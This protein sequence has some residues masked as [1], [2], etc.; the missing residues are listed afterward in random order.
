[1]NESVLWAIPMLHPLP[2]EE[3]DVVLPLHDHNWEISLSSRNEADQW[4][5]VSVPSMQTAEGGI[6]TYRRKLAIPSTWEGRRFFLR[7]DG[8]NCLTRVY[9]DGHYIMDHYGGF[10]SWDCPLESILPGSSYELVLEIEAR[11]Q[12]VSPFHQGGLMRD[13]ILFSLPQVCLSQLH[14][15]TV[16]DAQ[17]Q[18]AELYI[19]ASA[20]GSASVHLSLLDPEGNNLTLGSMQCPDG[21]AVQTV[22]S[23]LS[24]R[25]WDSEHPWLYTLVAEVDDPSGRR[26]EIVKKTFGFR[27][28]DHEG[29]EV[30][31][32]GQPIKL[33]GIN[34]HDVHPVLHRAVTRE[35]LEEDVRLFKEANI[36]F[37][38]T[39]HYPPSP[40][41]L[42]LCDRYGLYVEDESAVAFL[43]YALPHNEN[44]PDM[45]RAFIEPFTEL[46]ERDMDHP[47]VI[48]WSLAN[49]SYWG[50]HHSK[51][52]EYAHWRTPRHLTI[53]SYP[54][55]QMETDQPPDLWS[56]HYDRWDYKLNLQSE[57]FRRSESYAPER[58]VL[59]DE[60]THIP[61]YNISELRRDPGVCDFWG[62]TLWRFWDRI[63]ETKGA[64]GS[65]I[66]AGIDDVMIENNRLHGYPWGIIDGWRRKKPEYWHVRKGYSPIKVLDQAE[67]TADG[68][69]LTVLNRFNHTDLRELQVRWHAG[70]QTGLAVFPPTAPGHTGTI[71]F[72][73]SSGDHIEVEFI[74]PFNFPVDEMVLSAV[75]E[76]RGL[77]DLC[78]TPETEETEHTLKFKG[79]GF[80]LCFS[81]ESGLILSGTPGGI[82]VLTGGPFLHLPDLHLAPWRKDTMKVE[83][84]DE[85]TAITLTGSYGPVK[86]RFVIRFDRF[87]HLCITCTILDLPY[88]SPRR[89]AITS[90]LTA[91]NGGYHEVGIAFMAA[92]DLNELSWTRR[93]RWSNYPAWHIG[94]LSGVAH[95]ELPNG[96]IPNGEEPHCD[97]KDDMRDWIVHGP[98]DTGIHGTR[99]FTASREG[100]DWACLSSQQAGIMF[101]GEATVRM[102][103]GLPS[104]DVILPDDPRLQYE[105]S[106]K[107]L[108]NE[109]QT[110]AGYEM[111]A[112][113]SSASCLCTFE[114]T[115]IAWLTSQDFTCGCANIYLDG[116]LTAG[117]VDLGLSAMGK[118]PRGKI[119]QYG[120]TVWAVEGLN[121]GPHRLLI[122]VCSKPARGSH[123]AYVAIDRFLV[124]GHGFGE[125][126]CIIN[127]EINFPELSWA[128]YNKP[129]V[130]VSSGYEMSFS[131]NLVKKEPKSI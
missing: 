10:V 14:M 118:N 114:G 33:R 99:D 72:P 28:I 2:A 17:W 19:T 90:S 83:T 123:N 116:H 62:E 47:C 130:I 9:L 12:D 39:S 68:W 102:E 126:K 129:P 25:K 117:E 104:E 41:F 35:L 89:I 71:T 76:K 52:Q 34:H 61:C 78:G 51:M 37:I 108:D 111:I 15:D 120:Q 56:A 20:E 128:C 73:G 65:A 96:N 106:W 131:L 64:L 60:C 69:K 103:A 54:M 113:D 121:P 81:K 125:T 50:Y 74:D 6:L 5:P 115:G 75:E 119:R 66:W 45:E 122:E 7:F 42:D 59:H 79:E 57:C 86:V 48:I 88:P 109:W 94:R 8:A 80:E 67:H 49:E 40:H 93:G 29:R 92:P 27:Q 127:R 97:W 98:F 105:G 31:I 95:R 30:F 32:N 24:P 16:F 58:P 18:D 112:R 101:L 38:R 84:S 55:T 53:F 43:G 44:N 21:K 1:M 23:V 107:L 36:N 82:Q 4:E 87:G 26:T 124:L 100:I 13:V 110:P 11:T 3:D 85:Y 46:V 70:D 22:F 77:P 91:H 63:W